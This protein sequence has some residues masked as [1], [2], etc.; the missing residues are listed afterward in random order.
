MDD[1]N[2]KRITAW[3]LRGKLREYLNAVSEEGMQFLIY[4]G[5]DIDF[6][7]TKDGTG[8]DRN[9]LIEV[10]YSDFRQ[11]IN[12]MLDMIREQ[13]TAAVIK[14]RQAEEV[15]VIPLEPQMA[16]IEQIKKLESE[17]D[18]LKKRN[19]RLMKYKELIDN[20]NL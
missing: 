18:R 19:E 3:V 13:K 11:S 5:S 8:L 7:L 16:Y 10:T 20:M 6:L 2:K 9:V 15:F 12:R 14:S 17:N 4:D 1:K